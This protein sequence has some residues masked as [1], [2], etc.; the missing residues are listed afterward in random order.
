VQP[1]TS[2]AV[3]MPLPMAEG[4]APRPSEIRRQKPH[5][6]AKLTPFL[7]ESARDIETDLIPFVSAERGPSPYLRF[8]VKFSHAQRLTS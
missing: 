4:P 1:S 8:I 2:R 7:N 5:K 6:R 3:L